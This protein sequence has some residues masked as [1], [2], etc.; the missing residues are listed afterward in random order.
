MRDVFFDF[1]VPFAGRAVLE[2]NRLDGKG[3]GSPFRF[4]PGVVE[5]LEVK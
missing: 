1:R 5:T 3:A 2:G 4:G